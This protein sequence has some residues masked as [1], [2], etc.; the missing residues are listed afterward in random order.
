VISIKIPLLTI[1]PKLEKPTYC[2][3]SS[4][5]PLA[6]VHEALKH[7]KTKNNRFRLNMTLSSYIIIFFPTGYNGVEYTFYVIPKQVCICYLSTVLISIWNIWKI[8]IDLR[9]EM[10]GPEVSVTDII[11]H[12]RSYLSSSLKYT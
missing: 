1:R 12:L 7:M 11:N 8:N 5:K 2:F 3:Q 9:W 4:S 6:S 10:A